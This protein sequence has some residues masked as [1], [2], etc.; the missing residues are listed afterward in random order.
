[1]NG[2]KEIAARLRN[3]F[4]LSDFQ[5]R[6]EDGTIQIA[7]HNG[8]VLEKTE[9]FPYGFYAKAK[10]GKVLVVCQGG[11]LDRFE[12]L[13]VLK[14]E[15]VLLPELEEGAVALYTEAGGY[16]ICR[17]N[18][19]L[20]V[21]GTDNGGVVKVQELQNQL[22]KNN[23]ILCTLLSVFKGTPISEAG[24]GSP[25]ALQAA[26]ATALASAKVGDFSN[27]ASAEVF[28]GNGKN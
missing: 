8:K 15:D 7:T 16:V 3:L 26:L 18:G 19:A 25:S 2:I 5:R 24:D 9:A 1:M 20:E 6:Y 10:R 17:N 11:N 14:S 12:L 13:P 21:N 4:C 22:E 23:Q 28:H 27:I